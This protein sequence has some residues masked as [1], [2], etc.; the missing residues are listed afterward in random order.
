MP[1]FRNKTWLSRSFKVKVLTKANKKSKNHPSFYL[2]NLNGLFEWKKRRKMRKLTPSSSLSC[3]APVKQ[4]VL[5]FSFVWLFVRVSFFSSLKQSTSMPLRKSG[6]MS[7]CNEPRWLVDDIMTHQLETHSKEKNNWL[8][9][10]VFLQRKKNR[11]IDRF[12]PMSKVTLR[13]S[14][15][16]APVGFQKFQI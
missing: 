11:E 2:Y 12:S 4:C 5:H 3:K 1:I 7:H 13:I 14:N 15:L 6:S 16:Q 8:W 9:D 10:Y